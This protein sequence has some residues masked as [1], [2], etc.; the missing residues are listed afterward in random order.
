MRVLLPPQTYMC[1]HANMKT[2]ICTQNTYTCIIL[3]RK[4]IKKK[5]RGNIKQ[6]LIKKCLRVYISVK[7]C[8]KTKKIARNN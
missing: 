4:K 3:A 2:H 8:F 5:D 1:S 7:I 6:T